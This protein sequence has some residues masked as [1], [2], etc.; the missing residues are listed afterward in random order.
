MLP[1]ELSH[2]IDIAIKKLRPG[3]EFTLAGSN[4][5]EWKD[6]KNR[7]QPSWDEICEILDKLHREA[8]NK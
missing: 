7:P 6:P 1:F 8:T 3:A 5:I 4:I 2:G